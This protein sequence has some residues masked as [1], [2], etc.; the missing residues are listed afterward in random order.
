[1]T[2]AP[3]LLEL[4]GVSFDYEH[5]SVPV[6]AVRDASLAIGPQE[7][8]AVVGPSGS[9]KSTLLGILGLLHAPTAGQVLVRGE[10][11]GGLDDRRLSALRQG[12]TGF[13][14]Q[15]HHLL[16]N[17]DALG[18]VE[19]ALLLRDMPRATRRARARECLARV[20]LAERASHRPS[21][22]SGGEQQRVAVA[23]AIA[24]RPPVLLTDE[25]AGNLDTATRDQLLDLLDDLHADGTALVVVTHDMD[26]AARA[27]RRIDVVDGEVRTGS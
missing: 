6:H 12:T 4:R 20:G 11:V 13:V 10:D 15:Q 17:L 24:P 7:H 22:L 2:P 21:E 3:P 19:T 16:P 8:L 23:R 1:M 26:V 9:G 5:G 27:T 18:N 14:F 25:P